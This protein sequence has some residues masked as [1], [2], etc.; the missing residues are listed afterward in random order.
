MLIS[1]QM[2]LV[3]RLAEVRTANRSLAADLQSR[4]A[5]SRSESAA[6]LL[7]TPP[8]PRPAMAAPPPPP[9]P[10]PAAARDD[11]ATDDEDAVGGGGGRAG[12]NGAGGGGGGVRRHSEGAVNA[13]A[14]TPAGPSRQISMPTLPIGSPA[15]SF[16]NHTPRKGGALGS[17]RGR[18]S[19]MLGLKAKA[20]GSETPRGEVMQQM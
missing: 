14:S 6:L 10:V 20:K 17:A 8:P 12:R 19:E 13:I 1:E 11:D 18:L 4:L 5:L 2:Q 16:S 3:E 15:G 9:P 7:A